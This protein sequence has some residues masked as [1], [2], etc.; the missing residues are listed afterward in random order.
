MYLFLTK[1][2]GSYHVK[3]TAHGGNYLSAKKDGTWT[4]T[5]QYHDLGSEERFEITNK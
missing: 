2:D 1:I 5:T 3:T 4:I